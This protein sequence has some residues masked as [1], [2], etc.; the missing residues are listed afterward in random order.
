[1]KRTEVKSKLIPS[2]PPMSQAQREY[3]KA[4]KSPVTGP[5]KK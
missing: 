1:M 4:C 3:A 5:K 2:K